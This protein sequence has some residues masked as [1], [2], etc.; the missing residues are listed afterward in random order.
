MDEPKIVLDQETFK[1]LATGTRVKILKTLDKRR[2][3]QS[4][5]SAV[6]G[7]SVP[8]IKE[9]LSALASAGLVKR[10]EE[11]RKWIYYSLTEKSKCVLDPERKRLWIVLGFFVLSAV[12]TAFSA[13]KYYSA[14]IV[15]GAKGGA[16]FAKMPETFAAQEAAVQVAMDSA[17]EA[18]ATTLQAEI[19]PTSA[20][21][22]PEAI[23]QAAPVVTEV[24]KPFPYVFIG[25]VALTVILFILAIYFYRRSKL[26][27][28]LK[29]K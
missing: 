15:M 8:T 6:L 4:E 14:P 11:G 26:G 20:R 2:H 27:K 17:E 3:T 25:L 5:L 7:V 16:M 1:A 24:V 12:G 13:A 22:V 9:H 28:S 10:H 29:K 19:V 21:A 23:N 18:V